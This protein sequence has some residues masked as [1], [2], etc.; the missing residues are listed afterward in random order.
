M[1]GFVKRSLAY[2]RFGVDCFILR[3][4]R[5]HI[6]GLVTNDTCNL[7][8]IDCRVAN[9][10]RD[11]MRMTDIRN[12]LQR[13]YRKGARMLYLTGG[14]PYLWRDGRYRL[15]DVVTLAHE[16]G[17]LRVHVY[18]NGTARLSEIPDFHWISIDGIGETFER[19]RGIPL[20]RV[21]SHLRGFDG[22]H[23]IIFTINTLNYRSIGASLDYFRRV[24]P[25]TGTLF[26]FHTPYYG[27]DYL[28]LSDE[29]RRLA[30]E[31]LLACKRAGYPV[32]NSRAALEGFLHRTGGPPLHDSWIVDTTGDYR[33]CRVEG[34]PDICRDCGYLT[35]YEIVH[36]RQWRPGA[37][38]AL[39]RTH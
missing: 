16:I 3:S 9:I 37:I 12:V 2:A 20:E 6:L 7:D 38:R 34:N 18:T 36:A 14:E 35:G 1:T 23:A 8:C 15:A 11:V 29:Q 4:E 28:L 22:R 17:Y 13:Y 39:L 33:C 5:P 25:G 31:D 21:L 10:N 19:I 24:L 32:L 26:Y 27:K 30:V